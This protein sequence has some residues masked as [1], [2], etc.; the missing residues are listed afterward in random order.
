VSANPLCA[1]IIEDSEDD[2]ALLVRELQQAGY[3]LDWARVDSEA[4]LAAALPRQPWD[5]IFSDFTLPGFAGFDALRMVRASGLDIPFIFVSGTI[6][7]D[8][9]VQAMKDGAHDYILKDNLARLAPAVQREVRE[10]RSRRERRRAERRL[11]AQFAVTRALAESS[12]ATEAAPRILAATGEQL[13]WDVAAMWTVDHVANVL[14]LVGFWTRPGVQAPAFEAQTRTLAFMPGQGLAGRAWTARQAVWGEDIAG[15]P[16]LPRA[17][18]AAQDGLHSGVGVPIVRGDEV[19]GVIE[20]FGREARRPEQEVEHVQATVATQIGQFLERTRAEDERRESEARLR[21]VVEAALDG[22]ITMDGAGNIMSWNRQAEH[23]FGWAAVDVVGRPLADIIIPPQHREAHRKGLAHFL[24]T[25]SG[26]ILGQRIEITA[27]RR[28]DIEFPVE[29]TVTP[30]RLGGGLLFSAFVRDITER[31]QLQQRLIQSQKL[32]A[33]GQLAAGVAHDFNNVLTAIFGY[34]DLLIEDLPEASPMQ[35]DLE[36]V[37]KAAR[38]AAGLTRQLLA[39][40]R[41]QVLQPAVLNLNQIVAEIQKMLDRLIG[42]DIELHTVLA[43]T[44]GN[45][46]ADP[47]QLEQVLL[48]LAV[49]ARD[50]MPTGGRLTIETANAE[51]SEDYAAAHQPVVPGSYVMLA[52]SD[53]G[54]GMDAQTRGRIFEP[55]FT[56]KEKG[57]GTGLGL[58]TVYGIVKQSGGYIW[59]YSEPGHG[60]TFKVYLPRV[61]APIDVHRAVESAGTTSGTETVL[62]AE[63]DELLRPLARGVLVKLGYTVL[64]AANAAA[65]IAVARQHPGDIQLLI[66]DVVMPGESGLELARK[67]LGDRPNVRVLYI[68]GYTDEAVVRHGL[69]ERGTNFL[70]KPFTPATLA[71]KVREVLDAP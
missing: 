37:R 31:K 48:N 55:F 20:F 1:L 29:L 41:Q 39:F 6:G 62:L 16:S 13:D 64:D 12:N 46:H 69:L 35:P 15:D 17:D 42:A 57:K 58:A 43:P 66:S 21:A 8:R 65:A 38:R 52:V 70:Q 3:Q 2:A 51:L 14:R 24:A 10:A 30:V 60:A 9:A 11:A 5:V 53:T 33:V 45:V 19:L 63:D 18:A 68:S 23:M 71:R 26:P 44:A 67:L 27:L 40:S 4:T 36:E 47:G 25:G 28:G 59:V 61:D 32:E 54:T 56:T 7:E 49:N 22:V 50:A 34:V